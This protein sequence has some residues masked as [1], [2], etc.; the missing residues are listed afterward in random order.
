MIDYL[1]AHLLM[2]TYLFVLSLILFLISSVTPTSG[3][4]VDEDPT[5]SFLNV[6]N[7]HVQPDDRTTSFRVP[8]RSK[9]TD[10]CID[11]ADEPVPDHQSSS[12]LIWNGKKSVKQKK[13]D[14]V[15]TLEFIG[16]MKV[17]WSKFNDS[18]TAKKDVWKAIAGK[19]LFKYHLGTDPT[20]KCRLKWRN[21]WDAYKKYVQRCERTGSGLDVVDGVPPFYDQLIEIVGSNQAVHPEYVSDTLCPTNQRKWSSEAFGHRRTDDCGIETEENEEVDKENGKQLKRPESSSRAKNSSRLSKHGEILA[22][23]MRN[24]EKRDLEKQAKREERVKR[25]EEKE[26]KKDD[27][28]NERLKVAQTLVDTMRMLVESKKR[29]RRRSSSSSD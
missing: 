1:F 3:S 29:K 24:E 2:P 12:I 22:L 4:L 16:Y 18:L 11:M 10:G 28:H 6:H 27:R 26:K 8:W 23:L 13:I 14:D 9:P 25:E 5:S 20:E 17:Y 21:L 19:M 7:V 15:A